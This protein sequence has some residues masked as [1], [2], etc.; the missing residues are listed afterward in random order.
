MIKSTAPIYAP[1][2]PAAAQRGLFNTQQIEICKE[3]ALEHG[4]EVG[5][6]TNHSDR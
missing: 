4:L 2:L 3:Y 6:A 1:I 5:V